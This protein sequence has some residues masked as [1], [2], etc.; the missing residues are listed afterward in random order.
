MTSASTLL[1]LRNGAKILVLQRGVWLGFLRLNRIGV[2]DASSNSH[3]CIA[4][5]TKHTITTTS[6]G[7]IPD[8]HNQSRLMSLRI[9]HS[10]RRWRSSEFAG[11]LSCDQSAEPVTIQATVLPAL[12]RS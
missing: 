9:L 6:S 8:E 12:F 4:T 5:P 10:P 11:L 7:I 1:P 2:F 3:A